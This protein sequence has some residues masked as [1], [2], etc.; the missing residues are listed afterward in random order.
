[1]PKFILAYHGSNN[2]MTPKEGQ[3]YMAEWMKW[4]DG[5]GD[6][7]GSS[8][9]V[10]KSKT[11]SKNGVTDDSGSNPL[12]GVT[13]LEATDMDTAVKM[14]KGCPHAN[15]GTIKIAQAMEM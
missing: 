3:A 6:A 4:Q 1:M 5:L 12:S 7:L 2:E 11:I 14:V 9:P 15:I 8:M 10:G 13:I